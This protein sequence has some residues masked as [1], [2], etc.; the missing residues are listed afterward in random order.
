MITS[1]GM[2]PSLRASERIYGQFLP[3]YK[4]LN[5]RWWNKN[6]R[7]NRNRQRA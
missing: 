7:S 2:N 6:R 4:S 1:V 5:M 3:D